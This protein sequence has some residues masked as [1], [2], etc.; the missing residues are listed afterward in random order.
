MFVAKNEAAALTLTAALK[1]RNA[2]ARRQTFTSLSHRKAQVE[3]D[4]AR[5]SAE[6]R[7]LQDADV[8]RQGMRVSVT[9]TVEPNEAELRAMAP[10]LDERRATAQRAA[11]VVRNLAEG[12]LPPATEL[13]TYISPAASG[14]DT[15]AF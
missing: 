2:E 15:N 12:K 3:F 10:L 1:R 7:A 9:L 4:E 14:A 13:V 11:A 8:E 6:A 5:R